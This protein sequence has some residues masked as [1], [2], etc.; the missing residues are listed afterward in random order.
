M[1]YLQDSLVKIVNNYKNFL[2]ETESVQKYYIDSNKLISW[3]NE[4]LSNQQKRV[5]IKV[6]KASNTERW[7]WFALQIVR[8]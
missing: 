8:K 4:N 6:L 3:I 1:K 5:I 7:K 2:V